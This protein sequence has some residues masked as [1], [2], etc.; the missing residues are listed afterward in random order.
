MTTRTSLLTTGLF[1]LTVFSTNAQAR[2]NIV[3]TG[4][5]LSY[6]FED[7]QYEEINIGRDFSDTINSRNDEEYQSIAITPQ[8]RL[9]SNG[10]KDRFEVMASPSLK[11]DLIDS[12]TDWYNNLFLAAER[13]MNKNWRLIGSNSLLR[14]DYHESSIN[15]DFQT[16]QSS[17]PELSADFGR[18]Q[19]W[20][21]NL[22]LTSEHLYSQQSQ[23]DFSFDYVILR[24]DETETRTYEDYDRYVG[25][26][27][28][29]HR[30]NQNWQTIT[31]LSVIRGDF[32]NTGPIALL[33]EDDLLSD[34]LMEYRLLLTGENNYSRQTNL[35]LSYNYIGTRYDESLRVD[36]DIHQAQLRYIHNY[37]R[38]TTIILG[39]GPS[40]EK[41]ESQ[42]S[43]IG[44][45]GIVEINYQGQR[46]S[47]NFVIE[48][49]YDVDNFSGANERGFVDLW[50]TRL[51]ADYQIL[52]SLAIDGRI[53]Y[54]YEDRNDRPVL[55]DDSNSLTLEKYH[56]DKFVTGVGLRYNFLKNYTASLSYTFSTQDSDILGDDYDDH[57]VLLSLS[58]QQDVFRWK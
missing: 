29:E 30:F 41:S 58:W 33:T 8:I 31:D 44:G 18:T 14:S 19:Y 36:G 28:N 9:I 34:D 3:N 55:L 7:R 38:E 1:L 22:N 53:R 25:S 57:R 48:K 16:T 20:R 35:S 11:Y 43:N 17:S 24:N 5:S 4:L 47:F 15:S 45:N 51:I 46:K 37:S 23:L 42:D 56:K 27:T 49:R 50:E 52:A 10:L 2:V 12:E 54:T 13:S 26:I 6:D 39:A 21:N 32:E 40:Y